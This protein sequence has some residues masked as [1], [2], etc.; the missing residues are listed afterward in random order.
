M[1]SKTWPRASS[2]QPSDVRSWGYSGR[3]P[4]A[5]RT[6]SL[7]QDQPSNEV[8]AAQTERLESTHNGHSSSLMRTS[9]V[10]SQK[11]TLVRCISRLVEPTAGAIIVNGEDVVAMDNKQL[12]RKRQNI[13]VVGALGQR[14][15]SRWNRVRD[16]RAAESVPSERGGAKV[17]E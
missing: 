5:P 15:A 11:S 8:A 1:S 9:A 2:A 3:A 12:R 7:S 10:G 4:E 14:K 16:G 13:A 17:N 6:A